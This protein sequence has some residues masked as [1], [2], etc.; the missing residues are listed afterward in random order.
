VTFGATVFFAVSRKKHRGVNW[1]EEIG[2][3]GEKEEGKEGGGIPNGESGKQEN[4]KS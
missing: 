1:Q 2:G 3:A 4:R